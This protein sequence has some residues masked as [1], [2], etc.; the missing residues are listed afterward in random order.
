MRTAEVLF[1]DDLGNALLADVFSPEIYSLLVCVFDARLKH[2]RPTF[3]TTNLDEDALEEQLSTY[4]LSRI[5]TLCHMF[6][7]PGVDL[8]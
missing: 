3:I 6:I 8:R 7:L 1:L 2:N 5:Q 4:L